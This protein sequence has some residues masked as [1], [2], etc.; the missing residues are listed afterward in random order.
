MNGLLLF[1]IQMEMRLELNLALHM[2][3]ELSENR[4]M[5]V[6]DTQVSVIFSK[7]ADETPS[8]NITVSILQITIILTAMVRKEIALHKNGILILLKFSPQVSCFANKI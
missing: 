5:S 6:A 3:E 1:N 8:Y 4:H 7:P 2:G